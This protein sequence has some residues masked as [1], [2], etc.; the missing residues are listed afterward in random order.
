MKKSEVSPD[1]HLA[2]LDSPRRDDLIKLDEV[3]SGVL[4]GWSRVLWM[5]KFWGGTDQAIIGYGDYT[6]RKGSGEETEWF[7]VGL[8]EQKN[9]ISLYVNATD[10]DRYLGQ[11]YGSRLGKVK[12]GAA[13]IGFKAVDDLDLDVFNEMLEKVL[14]LNPGDVQT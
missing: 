13:S 10:H 6:Y 7:V 14:E 2:K 8:A 12:L 1:D 4:Q 9:Q 3:I 11:A 5:G